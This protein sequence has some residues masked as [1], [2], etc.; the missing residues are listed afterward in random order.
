MTGVPLTSLLRCLMR[1]S[2]SIPSTLGIRTSKEKDVFAPFSP[3][4]PIVSAAEEI[5]S[6]LANK[7]VKPGLYLVEHPSVRLIAEGDFA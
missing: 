6:L 1:S 2:N 7:M 5:K 4:M 3:F